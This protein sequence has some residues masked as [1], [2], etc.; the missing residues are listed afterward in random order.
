MDEIKIVRVARINKVLSKY[1]GL[2]H[3]PVLDIVIK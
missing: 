2:L 3:G 1:I